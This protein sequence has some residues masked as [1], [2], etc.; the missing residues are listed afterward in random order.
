MLSPCLASVTTGETAPVTTDEIP[1]V[2]KL[3][4]EVLS[5]LTVGHSAYR[6]NNT[7]TAHDFSLLWFN[8]WKHKHLPT[9][10]SVGKDIP[11]LFPALIV[12]TRLHMS[13]FWDSSILMVTWSSDWWSCCTAVVLTVLPEFITVIIKYSGV[14]VLHGSVTCRCELLLVWQKY[15]QSNAKHLNPTYS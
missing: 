4:A 1:S 9:C 7:S 10:I 3:V 6:D 5:V 8:V 2:P 12:T 13:T 15:T 11:A 14:L